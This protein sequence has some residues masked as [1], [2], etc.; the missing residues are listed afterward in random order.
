[1]TKMKGK[2]E[3]KKGQENLKI[4]ERNEKTC[5]LTAHTPLGKTDMKFQRQGNLEKRPALDTRGQALQQPAPNPRPCLLGKPS[6]G[7]A[8]GNSKAPIPHPL[9]VSLGQASEE[10]RLHA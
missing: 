4:N 6:P 3:K 1:M 7:F 9:A 8:L 5:K 2:L 10:V